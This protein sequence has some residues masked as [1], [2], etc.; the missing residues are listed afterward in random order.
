MKK[1]NKICPANQHQHGFTMIELMITV[2]LVAILASIAVPSMRTYVLNNRLNSSTQ[3]LLRT[4]QTAR[5]EAT[6]RQRNVVMCVSANPEAGSAA[7]CTTGTPIGWIV[8][9]D[10]TDDTTTST[11]NDWAHDSTE[12]LIES[13]TFDSSKMYV[14]ADK[15]KR[16]SYAANGFANTAG[17]TAAT[18]TP[19]KSVV[20]CDTRGNVDSSGGTTQTNSVAR[21]IIIADT[22]RAR[23]TKALSDITTRLGSTYI[24]SSCPPTP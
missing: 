16:V 17:T 20:I 9:Q 5:T 10:Y 8:F 4:L 1:A 12:E 13:H 3:E 15:S 22:G 24:N 7:T 18:Q 23:I 14:L 6:R 2:T 21:G 19:S 11:N